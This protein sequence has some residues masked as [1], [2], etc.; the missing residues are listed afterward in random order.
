MLLEELQEQVQNL[1]KTVEE[2]RT[3]VESLKEKVNEEPILI[4][5]AEYDLVPSIQEKVIAR[6]VARFVRFVDAP[7]DLGLSPSEWAQFSLDEEAHG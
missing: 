4:P 7:K 2:L 5:G 6:G 1:T 3:E